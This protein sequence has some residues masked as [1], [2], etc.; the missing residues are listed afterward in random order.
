MHNSLWSIIYLI[1]T[2][3]Y[4]YTQLHLSTENNYC[5]I[6]YKN[7]YICTYIV[8]ATRITEIRA[9]HHIL[10]SSTRTLLSFFFLFFNS[11]WHF[12]CPVFSI[13]FSAGCI[14]FFFLFFNILSRCLSDLLS[15]IFM[16]TGS[17]SPCQLKRRPSLQTYSFAH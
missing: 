13:F 5:V 14:F 3:Y 12:V 1:R 10:Q 6:T 11:P 8:Y 9:F 4:L 7:N 2:F 16:R 17:F 15:S